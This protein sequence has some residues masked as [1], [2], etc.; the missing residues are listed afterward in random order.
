MLLNFD[1]H[2][3]PL[4]S[5][6]SQSKLQHTHNMN[7]TVFLKIIHYLSDQNNPPLHRCVWYCNI[8]SLLDM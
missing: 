3:P 1:Q 8:C 5:I 4:F 7:L 2:T 6:R